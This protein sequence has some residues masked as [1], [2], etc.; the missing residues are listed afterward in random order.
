MGQ[1]REQI[2]R[3]LFADVIEFHPLESLAGF[4]SPAALLARYDVAQVQVCLYRATQLT[5]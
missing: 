4:D 3:E 5:V 2:E 1:P